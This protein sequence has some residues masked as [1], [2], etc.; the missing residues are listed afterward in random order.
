[1]SCLLFVCYDSASPYLDDALL[2]IQAE[3]RTIVGGAKAPVG[4]QW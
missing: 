1:M 4:R 3:G 2:G